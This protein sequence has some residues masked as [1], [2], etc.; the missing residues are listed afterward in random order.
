MS[1]NNPVQMRLW[2]RAGIALPRIN[3]LQEVFITQVGMLS[4]GITH[5]T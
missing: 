5:V 1:V 4:H 3:A 2:L